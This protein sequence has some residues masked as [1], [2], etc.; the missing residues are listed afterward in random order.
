MRTLSF[1]VTVHIPDKISDDIIHRMIREA[2][3]HLHFKDKEPEVTWLPD[4]EE[5]K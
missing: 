5:S 1:V 4:D 3:D 2:V